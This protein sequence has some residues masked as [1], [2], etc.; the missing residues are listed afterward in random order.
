MRWCIMVGLVWAG[1]GQAQEQSSGRLRLED[2]LAL[3]WALQ[4]DDARRLS[5]R[6]HTRIVAQP[7]LS[8]WRSRPASPR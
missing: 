8:S 1:A 6:A 2:V 5:R 7:E 4:F 3:Q